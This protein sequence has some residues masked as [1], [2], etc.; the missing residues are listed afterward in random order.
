MKMRKDISSE[1]K[2]V[3]ESRLRYLGEAEARLAVLKAR[4]KG[5]QH[6][7]R[8]RDPDQAKEELIYVI[9]EARSLHVHL[10]AWVNYV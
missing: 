10:Q 1:P 7:L 3:I 5:A 6:Y 9:N 4:V 2:E 8:R